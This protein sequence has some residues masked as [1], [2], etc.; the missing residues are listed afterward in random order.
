M[1]LIFGLYLKNNSTLDLNFYTIKLQQ[2][3]LN[4]EIF[5]HQVMCVESNSLQGLANH[6]YPQRKLILFSQHLV[7]SLSA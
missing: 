2:V 4:F 5:Y 3:L 1:L 6:F 7:M